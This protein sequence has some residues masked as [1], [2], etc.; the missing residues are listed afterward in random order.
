MS[1]PSP[2][3]RARRRLVCILPAP[4]SQ[5]SVSP[6]FAKTTL[7]PYY[8]R[9]SIRSPP[10]PVPVELRRRPPV[11][12]RKSRR[13]CTDFGFGRTPPIHED[14]LPPLPPFMYNHDNSSSAGST[15]QAT[16]AETESDASSFYQDLD[17]VFPQPPVSPAL[18][19]MQS[20]PLFTPEETNA[21][22]EFLRKRWGTHSKA[23]SSRDQPTASPVS[24][25]LRNQVSEQELSDFS[26]DAESPQCGV[27]AGPDA[28]DLE[29]AG[30]A[31]IQGRASHR[32]RWLQLQD[33]VYDEP[34]L[35]PTRSSHPHVLRRATSMASPPLAE[36]NEVPPLPVR[37]LRFQ[38]CPAVAPLQPSLASAGRQK[39]RHRPNLSVP[40]LGLG[41]PDAERPALGA[42]FTYHRPARSQPT[43][44]P[45]GGPGANPKS[46]IDLTP[47]KVVQRESTGAR[48]HRDRVKRL[49]SRAS[50]GFIGWSKSLTGG[51][52]RY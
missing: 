30:E 45:C 19:R 23:R 8:H 49:L 29:L 13:Y 48:A 46:F 22:R 43:N 50:S 38:E 34:P 31:L 51:K 37:S 42:S 20:S 10:P 36:L 25:H 39:P 32:D 47:E 9:Q 18:R 4:D 52:K 26:W 41:L 12:P 5:P 2:A 44:F 15:P 7:L 3:S 1:R 40:L 14:P 27:E 24:T 6:E 28:L 17:L 33:N 16:Y 11:D 21:V 35:R